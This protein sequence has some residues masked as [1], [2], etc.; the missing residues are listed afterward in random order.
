[1]KSPD[2][3]CMFNTTHIPDK[4]E[5]DCCHFLNDQEVSV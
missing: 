5:L 4:D 2:T 1:M 3:V